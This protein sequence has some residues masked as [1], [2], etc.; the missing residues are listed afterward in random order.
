MPAVISDVPIPPMPKP[1]PAN[2]SA[3]PSRLSSPMKG[4]GEATFAPRWQRS[5]AAYASNLENE[6]G[7][8]EGELQCPSVDPTR[9]FVSFRTIVDA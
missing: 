7:H 9:R 4:A 3:I 2:A 1:E 5:N 6:R 8:A